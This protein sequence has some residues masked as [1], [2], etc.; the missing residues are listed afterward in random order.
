MCGAAIAHPSSCSFSSK[1]KCVQLLGSIGF[2]FLKTNQI[3]CIE[4]RLPLFGLILACDIDVA[5]AKIPV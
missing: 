4:D 2:G 3:V 5:D 1:R